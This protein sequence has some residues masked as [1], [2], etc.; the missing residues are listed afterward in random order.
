MNLK[1]AFEA[2]LQGKKIRYKRNCISLR[3]YF[4]WK[5]GAIYYNDGERMT[6]L[7]TL[8]E[9][10]EYEEYEEYK[11][12]T[13]FN[14]AMQHIAGGGRVMRKHWNYTIFCNNKKRGRLTLND[15]FETSYYLLERQDIKAKD[16]IL[17]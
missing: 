2:L 11:E 17:L 9:Y 10:E 12:L 1:E 5:D 13:D 4:Y 3:K 14:T 6:L 15:E 7:D 16:W 8:T